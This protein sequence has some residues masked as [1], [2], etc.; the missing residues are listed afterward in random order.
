[1]MR[2]LA[3]HGLLYLNVPTNGDVHRFPVDCWRFYP[4]SGRALV[5]WGRRNGIDCELLESYVGP[6]QGDI[7]NDFVAVFVRDRAC[8]GRYPARIIDRLEDFHN[9]TRDGVPG[10]LRPRVFTEDRARLNALRRL[11]FRAAQPGRGESGS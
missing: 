6:Q 3:P 7:W 5:S 2:V 8:T 11:V 9:A 1:M 10:L 4:D